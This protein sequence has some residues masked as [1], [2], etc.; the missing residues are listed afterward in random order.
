M[1]LKTLFQKAS[2]ITS[3]LYSGIPFKFNPIKPIAGRELLSGKSINEIM[4]ALRKDPSQVKRHLESGLGRFACLTTKLPVATDFSRHA[5]YSAYDPESHY[6]ITRP[7]AVAKINTS[8][9]LNL[10]HVDEV[11]S[12]YDNYGQRAKQESE[13]MTV[14]VMPTI[15]KG[16]Y[17]N[18]EY[19]ENPLYF[20][21]AKDDKFIASYIEMM[22]LKADPEFKES[23]PKAMEAIDKYINAFIEITGGPESFNEKLKNLRKDIISTGYEIDSSV[24]MFIDRALML[25]GKKAQPSL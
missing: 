22:K 11:V 12:E 5:G 14:I 8:P 17:I 15:I 10:I 1:A 20:P 9:P 25:S 18:E 19:I 16:W 2:K 23:N 21:D 13:S 7:S 24:L 6:S 3:F 4:N